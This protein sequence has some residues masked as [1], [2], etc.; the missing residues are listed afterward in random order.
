MPGYSQYRRS[1][2]VTL[3][4]VVYAAVLGPWP[5]IERTSTLCGN[6]YAET[7][8]TLAACFQHLTPR[9]CLTAVLSKTLSISISKRCHMAL[10]HKAN[11]AGYVF[12]PYGYCEP[13]LNQT[14]RTWANYRSVLHGTKCAWRL[15]HIQWQCLFFDIGRTAIVLLLRHFPVWLTPWKGKWLL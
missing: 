15:I 8:L 3:Q 12:H 9:T 5:N 6:N 1:H 7:A 2:P 14:G 10:A 4:P 13:L 11:T